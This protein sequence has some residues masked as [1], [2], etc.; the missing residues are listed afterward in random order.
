MDEDRRRQLETFAETGAEM[1]ARRDA[2][3]AA[4]FHAI[5]E[6]LSDGSGYYRIAGHDPCDEVRFDQLLDQLGYSGKRRIE[7]E[8]FC[9]QREYDES[10]REVG[11]KIA[12]RRGGSGGPTY[13]SPGVAFYALY[14]FEADALDATAMGGFR[15]HVGDPVRLLQTRAFREPTPAEASA[16]RR[17][18]GKDATILACR[19]SSLEEDVIDVRGVMR[20]ALPNGEQ[21]TVAI[22]HIGGEPFAIRG[23]FAMLGLPPVLSDADRR[24]IDAEAKARGLVV[25]GLREDQDGIAALASKNGSKLNLLRAKGG[26]VEVAPYEPGLPDGLTEDQE[27]WVGWRVERKKILVVDGWMKADGTLEL[28]FNDQ[29]GETWRVGVSDDGAELWRHAVSHDEFP[30]G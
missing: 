23:D 18:Y 5:H 9:I 4:T 8:V 13:G 26:V 12:R 28:I 3:P 21:E 25:H 17:F 2:V 22:G 1:I 6:T 11:G 27:D 7:V 19:D 30:Q 16:V 10:G 24:L 20:I 14:P 15:E 29:N